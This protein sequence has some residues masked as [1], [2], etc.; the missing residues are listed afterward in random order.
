MKVKHVSSVK[1][2]TSE[3]TFIYKISTSRTVSWLPLCSN[4]NY[5]SVGY[6][7]R[8]AL[9]NSMP[10]FKIQK[11]STKQKVMQ[12]CLP[13]SLFVAIKFVIHIGFIYITTD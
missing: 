6:I 9:P 7:S 2:F 1:H 11:M 12:N 4:F 10:S 13:L 8:S 3:C 5:T